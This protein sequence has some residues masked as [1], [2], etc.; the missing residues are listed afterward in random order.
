M[1]VGQGILAPAYLSQAE[2]DLWKKL[3]QKRIDV[4]A[5]RP[6]QTW[7]IEIMERPGLAAVGQLIGYQHLYAKYVEDAGE[8][9]RC[10]DLCETRLRH[11]TDF[12]QAARSSFSNSKSARAR[13]CRPRF[14]RLW[15]ASRSRPTPSRKPP[16]NPDFGLFLPWV[17]SGKTFD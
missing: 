15:P 6:G 9:C 12:R 8:I 3:T 14:S 2:K 5:E 13:C 16:K 10:I 11:E 7:I 1:R 4:V 17:I